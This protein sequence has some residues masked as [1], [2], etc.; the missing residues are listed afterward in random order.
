M[1]ETRV[2]L[3]TSTLILPV[4]MGYGDDFWGGDMDACLREQLEGSGIHA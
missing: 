2:G 1:G 4:A 3:A